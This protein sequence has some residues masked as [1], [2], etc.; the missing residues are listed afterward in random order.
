MLVRNVVVGLASLNHRK[1]MA[2]AAMYRNQDSL[3]T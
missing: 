1:V 3:S 2:L